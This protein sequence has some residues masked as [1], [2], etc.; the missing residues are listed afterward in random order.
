MPRFGPVLT[1]MVT[2]MTDDGEVDLDGVGTLAA[3]LVEHGND[4]LVVTGTTGEASMPPCRFHTCGKPFCC[5]SQQPKCQLRTPAWQKTATGLEAS[6]SV[7]ICSIQS[8][9]RLRGR[10]STGRGR[11]AMAS[12]SS[13]RT[14]TSWMPLP[15]WSASARR[16]ARSVALIGT[17]VEV[18]A[19][20][21]MEGRGA[22]GWG[23][24]AV[25]A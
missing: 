17:G 12:S 1:A 5:I 9:E 11:R 2:P 10:C 14:S 8:P 4:G 3:W 23:H 19:A 24:P 21:A 13:S 16:P 20:G 7:S 22:A 18:G 15:A 25:R 6:S